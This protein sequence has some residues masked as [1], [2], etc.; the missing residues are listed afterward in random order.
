M[1]VVDHHATKCTFVNVYRE[2]QNREFKLETP[3]TFVMTI[4]LY[5]RRYTKNI[6]ST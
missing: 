6:Y 5:F 2:W 4:Y 1:T 3:E